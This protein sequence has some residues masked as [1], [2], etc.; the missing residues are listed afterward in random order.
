MWTLLD[1]FDK[2]VADDALHFAYRHTPLVDRDEKLWDLNINNNFI[3]PTHTHIYTMKQ[4][5]S[6]NS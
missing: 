2:L 1:G 4:Q 6:K 5:K 3:D